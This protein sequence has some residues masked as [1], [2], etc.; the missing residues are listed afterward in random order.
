M[1]RIYGYCFS[2]RM[3]MHQIND[4]LKNKAFRSLTSPKTHHRGFTTVYTTDLI[5][6]VI[7]HARSNPILI[8]QIDKDATLG[9][10]VMLDLPA[11]ILTE[12]HQLSPA[13]IKRANE[14]NIAVLTTPYTAVEV[15]LALARMKLI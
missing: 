11:I 3:T 5:S 13:L 15:V 4:I 9:V 12:G 7:R 2:W 8:T 10:A 1:E 14:E 6:M